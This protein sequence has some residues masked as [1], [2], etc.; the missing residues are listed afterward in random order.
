MIF[1]NG[2]F[3]DFVGEFFVRVLKLVFFF[4][5]VDLYGIKGV[6]LEVVKWF[7]DVVLCEVFV[8]FNFDVVSCVVG[9][10]EID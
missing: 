5:F 4:L 6:F 3:V 10:S 1:Y 8:F 2:E 9:C 7:F